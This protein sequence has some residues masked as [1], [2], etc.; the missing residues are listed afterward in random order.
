MIRKEEMAS[1]EVQLDIRNFFME[2][3]GVGHWW[4]LHPKEQLE[5]SPNAQI[6]WERDKGWI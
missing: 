2:R 1:G 4:S 5:L 3:I 6:K